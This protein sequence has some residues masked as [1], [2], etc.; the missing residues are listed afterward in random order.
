M[1]PWSLSDPL[2]LS[3]LLALVQ[4]ALVQDALVQEGVTPTVAEPLVP[5]G[6]LVRWLQLLGTALLVGCVAFRYAVLLPLD[7][8]KALPG[9]VTQAGRGLRTLAW[10]AAGLLVVVAPLRLLEPVRTLMLSSQDR[11]MGEAGAVTGAGTL[12]FQ[13]AWGAGWWLHLAVAAMA[14]VGVILLRGEEDRSRGW[15]ILAGAALLVPLAPALSGNAWLLDP[16]VVSL[17]ATYLHVLA[18]GIWLGGLL[19]LLLAGLPA[20]RA[21]DGGGVPAGGELPALARM[22]NAF[23][24]V[25]LPAV[26]VLVLTGMV[27][28][29]L[30]LGSMGALFGSGYG[31]VLLF[32]LA[33]VAAAFLLGFYN[34]RKVRPSLA[35]RPDPGELRIPASLEAGLGILVLLLTAILVATP[36]PGSP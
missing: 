31:R 26:V 29:A 17:S 2:A 8:K 36:L 22:V 30:R 4:D 11:A 12:L 18:M 32:K 10:S 7:R 9:I 16:R 14:L 21:L 19:T 35:E 1:E 6:T 20:I 27:S 24:R 34:W 33:L 15:S 3:S 25:A 23:S 5:Q 13:T 28:N